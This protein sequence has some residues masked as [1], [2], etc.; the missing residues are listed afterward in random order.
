[1]DLAVHHGIDVWGNDSVRM[2]RG[3]NHREEGGQPQPPHSHAAAAATTTKV[4]ATFEI[5]R[6]RWE[7]GRER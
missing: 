4:V 1:M 6:R 5:S 7:E 3:G 2:W